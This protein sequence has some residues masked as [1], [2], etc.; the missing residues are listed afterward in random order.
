[1]EEDI[2]EYKA[3]TSTFLAYYHFHQWQYDQLI[4][5][6]NIKYDSLCTEE[7]SLIS[8]YPSHTSALNRC[9]EANKK[10]TQ[11]LA[12]MMAENFG[13]SNEPLMWYEASEEDFD[14]VRSILLQL[15]R[16]WSPEGAEER[17]VF[18]NLIT[19]LNEKYPDFELRQHINVL[20][21]GCGL[22]RLVYELVLNGYRVQG[23]EF[24]Y[25][26]L[27]MSN[28][29]LNYCKQKFEIYPFL[30]KLSNVSCRE[31]QIR[32][33]SIP[34]NINNTRYH[35]L[36]TKYHKVP[37][38]ELMSI[39]AGSFTDL[40][41]PNELQSNYN[42]PNEFRVSNKQNFDAVLTC[43]FLDTAS[44]VIEYLK[45]LKYVLKYDGLWIN[46]GPIL[47]HFEGDFSM[48]FVQKQDQQVPS[49]M[50]GLELSQTD[51]INLIKDIG[52]QFLSISSKP[53]TTTYATDPQLLSNFMYNCEFWSCK[54]T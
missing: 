7:Q 19:E 53:I 36:T 25:H 14:K 15:A 27:I 28:F 12:L 4:K 17:I 47:W 23:N 34:E 50:K 5:P 11:S 45:T 30:M 43:F 51:L 42:A 44:N 38:A 16:E 26:M 10:F 32:S 22:G 1:M 48:N 40:Y 18:S 54:L 24:S 46:I 6:R 39:T 31:N 33:V 37:F 8:W 41:G 29:I 49:I 3:L 21:P 20:I 35:D 13:I 52:F 9:I 2:E